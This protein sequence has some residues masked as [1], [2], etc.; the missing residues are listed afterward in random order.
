[1]RNAII[2]ELLKTAIATEVN[3]VYEK[4]ERDFA[5]AIYTVYTSHETP[6]DT[7]CSCDYCTAINKVRRRHL[8][9][10]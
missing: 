10:K 5:E 6:N 3:R 9:S 8:D 4:Y 1:M 7:D 2:D